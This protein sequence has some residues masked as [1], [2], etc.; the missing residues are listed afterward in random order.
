MADT[1]VDPEA[2]DGG[3]LVGDFVCRGE[4]KSQGSGFAAFFE[5]SGRSD[6]RKGG[7]TKSDEASTDSGGR[8]LG[9]V[10]DGGNVSDP[11]PQKKKDE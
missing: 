6:D 7:L 1:K 5:P 8:E 9:E 11:S 2:H 10:A 3:K 4:R